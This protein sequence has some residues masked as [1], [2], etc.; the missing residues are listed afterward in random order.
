MKTLVPIMI[1]LFLSSVL[2]SCSSS[3]EA[4]KPINQVKPEKQPIKDGE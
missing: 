4:Y 3:I 2:N 1:L